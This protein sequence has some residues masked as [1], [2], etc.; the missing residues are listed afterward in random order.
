VIAGRL[1][2]PPPVLAPAVDRLEL[3]DPVFI[4]DL[5]LSAAR[6][7]TQEA[8]RR[9]IRSVAAHHRELLILGDLF[10]AWVGDDDL[11]DAT[12]RSTCEALGELTANGVRV[13]L[14]HGNRDLLLGNGFA[15]R[16]GAALLI[17]PTVATIGGLQVLMAHGDAWCTQDQPYQRFRARSRRPSW[18]RGFLHLPLV[19]R[20]A[21]VAHARSHSE[22]HKRLKAA[23][24]MDVAPDAID[25][26]LR[27]AGV[28][29][30]IHGHTHRPA[31]HD[32]MLDGAPARRIVLTDW[33]FDVSP[34]R[35]GYLRFEGADPVAA[36]L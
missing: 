6:P 7:K 2:D 15:R 10:D 30:M 27:N 12:A 34:P 14:M 1:I 31:Q 3:A 21:F 16:I 29:T 33:D 8:F 18:Q 17:D 5:H 32:F 26:A 23:E 9:F 20:R 11:A 19:L 4:S 28:A 13:F 35:G 25:A 36:S 24:I 22:R